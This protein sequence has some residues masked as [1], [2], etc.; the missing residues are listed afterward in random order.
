MILSLIT[1][2]YLA[3]SRLMS[4]PISMPHLLPLSLPLPQFLY[5]LFPIPSKADTPQCLLLSHH[6]IF[7]QRFFHS[8]PVSSPSLSADSSSLHL[9]HPSIRYTYHNWESTASPP[10]PVLSDISPTTNPAIEVPFH[11]YSLRNRSTLHPLTVTPVLTLLRLSLHLS[12]EL[13]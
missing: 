4:P 9:P 11:T 7:L 5:F 13:P 12:S 1:F 2:A 8:S 3:M 6:V 10:R